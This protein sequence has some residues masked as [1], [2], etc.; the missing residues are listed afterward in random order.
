MAC[1][2]SGVATSNPG[3]GGRNAQGARGGPAGAGLRR[4][5]VAPY[6]GTSIFPRRPHPF[7]PRAHT[8][9]HGEFLGAGPGDQA[10]LA[11]GNPPQHPHP[12]SLQ[13]AS[14]QEGPQSRPLSLSYRSMLP[15]SLTYI[16][17]E[18]RGCSPWRPDAVSGTTRRESGARSP[19]FSRAD[20][21][22]PNAPKPGAL[23]RPSNLISGRTDSE[24]VRACLSLLLENPLP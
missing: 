11:P 15:T 16:I 17:L 20:E 7:F 9:P 1:N 3:A 13:A 22:V 18:S 2:S 4:L 8:L 24:V 14:P 6:A 19:G 23:Y 21:G 10:R 12:G 5:R